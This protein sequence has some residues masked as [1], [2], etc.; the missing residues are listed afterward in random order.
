MIKKGHFILFLIILEDILTKINI[1]SN[2][3]QEK[4]ATLGKS[5]N[6]INSIIKTV[7]NDRCS[8]K[9]KTVWTEVITLAKEFNISL[10]ISAKGYLK[11]LINYNYNILF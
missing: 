4:K 5:V 8:E 9:F 11:I 7:E 2:L 6:L 3:M 10:E 1:L